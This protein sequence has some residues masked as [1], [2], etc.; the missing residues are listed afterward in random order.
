VDPAGAEL[1]H[2]QQGELELSGPQVI[3]GYWEQP[4]ETE[5]AMGRGWLRTGDGAIIDQLGWVYL[6]DRETVAGY[7]SV[8]AGTAVSPDELIA[9][10][11]ERLAPYKCPCV[12][13]IVAELPKTQT[14][15]IRRNV[16]R[17][18]GGA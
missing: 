9:F 7:V 17:D 4:K 3:P 14:G 5:Q 12:V 18:T 11:R 13:H 6:V 2:G 1:D 8:K 10:V 16:L 15:K